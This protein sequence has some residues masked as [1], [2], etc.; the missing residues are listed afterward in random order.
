MS[1]FLRVLLVVHVLNL[2]LLA[3]AHAHWAELL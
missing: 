1:S 2:T 3:L